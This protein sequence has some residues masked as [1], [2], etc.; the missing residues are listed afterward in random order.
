MVRSREGG[1][2]PTI[3]IFGARRSHGASNEARTSAISLIVFAE[4]ASEQDH[5]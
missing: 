2:R 4:N 1:P 5:V 3:T